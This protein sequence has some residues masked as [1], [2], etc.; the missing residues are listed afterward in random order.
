MQS[1]KFVDSL[2]NAFITLILFGRGGRD[3]LCDYDLNTH[4]LR[5]TQYFFLGFPLQDFQFGIP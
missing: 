4:D 5:S 2:E 1:E 3:S